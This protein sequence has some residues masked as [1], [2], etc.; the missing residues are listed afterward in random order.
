M[1]VGA[2]LFDLFPQFL[3]RIKIRRVGGQLKHRDAVLVL[4]KEGLQ[5]RTGV[6]ACAVLD[7]DEV[8]TGWLST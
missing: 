6:I 1:Q 3:N 5:G 7:Q 8:L 4:C 2:M